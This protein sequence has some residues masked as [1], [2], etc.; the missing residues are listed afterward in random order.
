MNKGLRQYRNIRFKTTEQHHPGSRNHD[1]NK[2]EERAD[3]RARR[4]MLEKKEHDKKDKDL[5]DDLN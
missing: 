4:T 1:L 5:K 2:G 3:Q